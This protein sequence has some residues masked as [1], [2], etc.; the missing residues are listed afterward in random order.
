MATCSLGRWRS[1]GSNGILRTLHGYRWCWPSFRAFV[2]LLV[3]VVNH[4]RIIHVGPI[5]TTTWIACHSNRTQGTHI[6]R[7]LWTLE[8]LLAKG[9]KRKTK[10]AATGVTQGRGSPSAIPT[11][12][13]EKP[14]LFRIF[15]FKTLK[16]GSPPTT[17]RHTPIRQYIFLS[18]RTDRTDLTAPQTAEQ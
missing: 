6:R 9:T 2:I 15:K 3:T 8:D 12:P 16:N 10:T 5:T 13:T 17:K 4:D 14:K 1:S 11:Q 7:G 18:D